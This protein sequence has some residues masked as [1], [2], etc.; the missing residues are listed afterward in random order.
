MNWFEFTIRLLA[1][2]VTLYMVLEYVH[3]CD[4]ETW[5]AATGFAAVTVVV[6]VIF[7]LT[8]QHQLQSCPRCKGKISKIRAMIGSSSLVPV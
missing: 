6:V 8:K 3:V 2:A 7:F 4:V 1:F 5:K